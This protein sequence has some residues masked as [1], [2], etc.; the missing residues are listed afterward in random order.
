M[1][2]LLN[3][4]DFEQKCRRQ[5]TNRK[6]FYN[7]VYMCNNVIYVDIHTCNTMIKCIEM[8]LTDNVVECNTSGAGVPAT[9]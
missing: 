7:V 3:A 9:S 5:S 6:N 2:V 1:I 8:Y 4:I